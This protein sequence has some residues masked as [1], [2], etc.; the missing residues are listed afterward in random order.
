[1]KNEKNEFLA[2]LCNLYIAALLALLPLY[3]HEGY[4]QMG[5]EK[6]MLFC[7]M[8]LLCL[9]CWLA[10]G[11]PWQLGRAVSFWRR[12]GMA[13]VWAENP[14]SM[15]DL[16]ML[17]YGG[18]VVLSAL[19]SSYKELA[20][21]GYQGWYMGAASQLLFVAIYFFVSR[22]FDGAG[23]PVR[24][25]EAALVLVTVFG[26]LHRLGL[27]PLGLMNGWNSGDWEYSHMLSTLGNINW[28]CGYYSVA[29][30]VL[31][32]HYLQ[33]TRR[34]ILLLLYPASAAAFVLL[35][36]QGSQ[37]GWLLLAVC[38]G[39]CILLGRRR[40]TVQRKTC[41]LLAGF[42][43]SMP[44]MELLM[45]LRGE[46]AAIVADGNIFEY[47]R[48]YVWLM[49][50]AGCM[51]LFFLLGRR[52]RATRR[53]RSPFAKVLRGI[54]RQPPKRKA[55]LIIIACSVIMAGL[56]LG[57]V[58]LAGRVGDGF[59]SGRG[60]L[61]RISLEG[62]GQADGKDKLLG[63]G[64][65]CFGE[66]VFNRLGAG[67]EVW[68]GEHWEGAVFTNAHSEFLSQLC[69][70][71]ILGTF[72]YL[73]IFVTGLWRYCGEY[74]L[75]NQGRGKKVSS[76]DGS[77][78][79]GRAQER[80]GRG[81]GRESWL[82]ALVLVLYGVH[83]Q[84]SFQQVLN[85][86]LLF[87]TVGLCEACRRTRPVGRLCEPGEWRPGEEAGDAVREKTGGMRRKDRQTKGER[88][89]ENMKEGAEECDEVEEIQD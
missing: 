45:K 71:G 37:S 72:S 36:I 89:R 77:M 69:N 7:N 55:V 62:F 67:T 58:F 48:W 8:S 38:T 47:V 68:N 51:A 33:E 28:L 81:I 53:R 43:L 13:W 83:A 24:L 31:T 10:V 76:P 30:A 50:A 54:R 86:P 3:V 29:L 57:Y 59:G 32:T 82:G 60:F 73:A 84:I 9:G 16:A 39:M 46:K 17:S 14:F 64:P 2:L 52:G 56:F 61:W 34:G 88:C 74:F 80:K 49:G 6:Y 26:L 65:D 12:H 79:G 85:T 40:R 20:W 4:W 42:F 78:T 41:A 18:C 87:L 19:C 63:A 25:G 23:W 15:V 1:M 27:D 44:L 66:A 22:Q 70:V 11:I 21:K 35:G 5:N 75:E